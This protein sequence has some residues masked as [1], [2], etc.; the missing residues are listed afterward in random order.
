MILKNNKEIEREFELLFE[1]QK[2]D[3]KYII[4][5]DIIGGS[6]YTSKVRDNKLI[7]LT[8][9][10]YQYIEKVVERING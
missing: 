6:L 3:N 5:K 1:I 9:E 10:E 2:D 8:E 4:Y 7:P